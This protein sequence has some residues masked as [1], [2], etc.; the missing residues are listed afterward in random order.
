MTQPTA[1]KCLKQLE[2]LLG[3]ELFLRKGRVIVIIPRGEAV[4]AYA[5]MVF[6]RLRELREELVSIERADIGRVR[7]GAVSATTAV[8][9]TEVIVRLTRSHPGLNLMIQVETSDL[10]MQALDNE[11]C[12]RDDPGGLVAAELCL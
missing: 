3:L 6:D 9:L 1:S 11:P 7:I 5:R 8:L 10:L 2:S 4:T 12:D